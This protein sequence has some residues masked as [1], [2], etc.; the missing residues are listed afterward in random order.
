MPTVIR[1]LYQGGDDTPGASP[2]Q[3]A[4]AARRGEQQRACAGDKVDDD[5]FGVGVVQRMDSRSVCV[6]RL[7]PVTGV[8]TKSAHECHTCL[9]ETPRLSLWV[10]RVSTTAAVSWTQLT[11]LMYSLVGGADEPQRVCEHLFFQ[12]FTQCVNSDFMSCSHR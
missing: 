9:F 1:W 12:L 10:S 4:K 3:L 2:A 5:L 6:S 7:A 8:V 11:C